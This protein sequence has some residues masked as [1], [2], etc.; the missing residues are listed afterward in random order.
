MTVDT[1]MIN[2]K[3]LPQLYPASK[4]ISLSMGSDLSSGCLKSG[5][6]FCIAGAGAGESEGAEIGAG[7]GGDCGVVQ[8]RRFA[9]RVSLHAMED[10]GERWSG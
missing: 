3:S 4:Y 7:L 8:L 9:V 10:G 1:R 6:G 5:G 2:R